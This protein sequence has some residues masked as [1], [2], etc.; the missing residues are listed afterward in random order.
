LINILDILSSQINIEFS[1]LKLFILL[2]L[3]SKIW[4]QVIS[5]KSIKFLKVVVFFVNTYL[6]LKFLFLRSSLSSSIFSIK[7]SFIQSSISLVL[8]FER[9]GRLIKLLSHSY[10]L[11]YDSRKSRESKTIRALELFILSFNFLLKIKP[12]HLA[13]SR[14]VPVGGGGWFV[15]SI[16]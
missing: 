3:L 2:T 7:R 6:Y 5:L 12:F 16:F 8:F 14:G 11:S 13:F 10:I 1:D 4:T 9:A 15:I